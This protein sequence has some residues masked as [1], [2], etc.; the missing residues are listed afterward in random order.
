MQGGIGSRNQP[1]HP[2]SPIRYFLPAAKALGCYD[3]SASFV[4]SAASPSDRSP[5]MS[6]G[7]KVRSTEAA[8]AHESFRSAIAMRGLS[9]SGDSC[10]LPRF[11]TRAISFRTQSSF[12]GRIKDRPFH[13]AGGRRQE[14]AKE[15]AT[16]KP[17]ARSQRKSAQSWDGWP[18]SI[19]RHHSMRWPI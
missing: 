7:A 11:R 3:W 16:K 10:E 18:C 19:G 17:A 12:K 1:V 13:R 4:S 15:T 2:S 8:E 9:T 6:P 5:R 14:A